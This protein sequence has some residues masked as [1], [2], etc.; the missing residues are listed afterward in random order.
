MSIASMIKSY[1]YNAFDGESKAYIYIWVSKLHRIVYVGMTNGYTGTIGRA[2]GHFINSGNFRKRFSEHTG[3]SINQVNDFV[4]LSFLLPQKRYF[5]SEERSYREAVE[6]LV[7]KQ[8]QLQ[9]SNLSPTFTIV[10]WVRVSPRTGNSEIINVADSIVQ[11]F[12]A[13][14]PSL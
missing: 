7:Q 4:L 13:E 12:L 5:I 2:N 6:Y 14:Y 8:L 9:R 10:S 3:Y 11:D 1:I